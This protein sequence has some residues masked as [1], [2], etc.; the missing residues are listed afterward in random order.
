[1]NEPLGNTLKPEQSPALFLCSSKSAKQD[2]SV[3]GAGLHWLV[4]ADGSIFRK[5]YKLFNV[6]MQFEISHSTRVWKWYSLCARVWGN[7]L[8]NIWLRGTI[9]SCPQETYFEVGYF[10]NM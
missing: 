6:T 8:L 2:P 9:G 4:K 5:I 7:L 3:C 1:M 10:V